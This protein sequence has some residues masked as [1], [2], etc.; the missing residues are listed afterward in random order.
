MTG[1][2]TSHPDPILSIM[3]RDAEAIFQAGLRAVKPEEAIYNCCRYENNRLVLG[4]KSY[5]LNDIRQIFVVGAGKA[6]AAMAQA[7]ENLLGARISDGLISVKY[8]HS[9][10]LQHI[11]IIEAG[12]PLPDKNGCEAARRILEI[13]R[14]ADAQDL[15]IVLLSGGGSALLVLPWEGLT[16]A[17]KQISSDLLLASGAT[18][19]EINALRKHISAVKGGRLAR[20]AYPAAMATLI[21]S[22][23]VGDDLDVIASGPTVPDRSSFKDCL[24]IARHY[25]LEQKLPPAVRN[26]LQAGV[27]GQR[28]ETPKKETP[29][30]SHCHNLIV[31]N[32]A[33]AIRAAACEAENRGYKPLILSTRLEGETRIV[34][35]VHGAIAREVAASGHPLPSPA[36][37]LSGGETTVTLKGRGK[38]GRN[39]EFALAA[40]LDID[41]VK[42]IVIL[43]GGSDGS[44]GPTDA[45]GAIA[46]TTTVQRA[47]Q[48]GL[49]IRTFLHNNDAYTF[50]QQ[51]GD[52]LITGPTRTNVMDL[53]IVLVQNPAV[54]H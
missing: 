48:Q 10:P 13:V 46:D 28:P 32:N 5:N 38:G 44:D 14:R 34:A 41:G 1:G 4:E 35:Q 3:R 2:K 23:V 22:D 19:H 50:F 11:P 8:G 36:C 42:N 33:Q 17:D 25:N 39:Q 53:H 54:K 7:I 24:D 26:H 12:H 47:A 21:L 27:A 29:P 52:L 18:I 45:A 49:D 20:A 37:L 43:S 51:L 16:L 31:A 30:W 40:G 15:V 6:S 9:L